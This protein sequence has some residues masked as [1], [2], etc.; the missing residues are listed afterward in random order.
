MKE[1][2]KKK[3]EKK[4]EQ[5]KDYF[6]EDEEAKEK[7]KEIEEN[8]S[9]KENESSNKEQIKDQERGNE[10]NG[11]QEEEKG[12]D[13]DK[14]KFGKEE[15]KK[16]EIE[17]DEEIYDKTIKNI[18]LIND[19]V[20]CYI[21]NENNKKQSVEIYDVIPKNPNNDCM[22]D[23]AVVSKYY[24]GEN[25]YIPYYIP[26]FKKRIKIY[27]S[28]GKQFKS[29]ICFTEDIKNIIKYFKMKNPHYLDKSSNKYKAFSSENDYKVFLFDK[30][31]II[32]DISYTH[33]DYEQLKDLYQKKENIYKKKDSKIATYLKEVNDNIYNYSQNNNLKEE[34]I[35][36][37]IGRNLFFSK[38]QNI[39]YEGKK[40]TGIYGN[41]SSGKSISLIIFNKYAEF[42][43]LYLNLKALKYSFQ[44]E[45]YAGILPNEV[46]NI[47]IK[48][49]KSYKDYE[50]FIKKIYESTFNTFDEFIDSI[51]NNFIE[52]KA[53]IFLDQYSHDLF[54]NEFIEK[55]KQLVNKKNANIKLLLINSMNDKWSRKIFIDSIL[56]FFR[57]DETKDD[58]EFIFISKL[59]TE[60][61]KPFEKIDENLI[62]YLEPF[63]YLPKYYSLIMLKKNNIDDFVSKTKEKIKNKIN[64]FLEENN[65]EDYLIQMNDVRLKIDEEID[66]KFFED[67]NEIIPFKYFYIE[68]EYVNDMPKAYLKCHF[69][70]IKEIW[71]EIIYSKTLSLFDGEIKY[72][73]SIIGSLLELNFI[74]QCQD[75]KDKFSLGIDCIVE[76]DS[77]YKMGNIT[78]RSTNNYQNKNILLIQKNENAPCFDVGFLNSKDTFEPSMTY[79]QIKKTSTDNK[80]NKSTTLEIFNK[81][82]I[83]FEKLF[84][85]KPK[86]C[87]LIYI[88]LINTNIKNNIQSFEKI[89]NKEQKN[90]LDK[91]VFDYIKKINDLDYFCT[92]DNILLYYFYPNKG[93]FYIRKG[94]CFYESKLDLCDNNSKITK[95]FPLKITLLC[96]KKE[97][98]FSENEKH[99]QEINEKYKNKNIKDKFIYPNCCKEYQALVYHFINNYCENAVIKTY[100]ELEKKLENYMIYNSQEDIILLGIIK[101]F[102]NNTNDTYSIKSVIYENYI[103]DFNNLPNKKLIDTSELD[104]KEYDLLVWIQFQ[105]FKLNGNKIFKNE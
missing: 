75:K 28:K 37:T 24:Y 19:D 44:T 36:Y 52:W 61:D 63:G 76:L 51:I 9:Q 100:L 3:N 20:I 48:N 56:K 98:E 66:L 73:G 105:K 57:K 23:G 1:E 10:V 83:T 79:I 90:N 8:N 82:K 85:I 47:Y 67:H 92:Q 33:I 94:S 15:E 64:K 46:M 81:N 88:T 29:I 21:G 30:S 45:G 42:P 97:R 12:K 31:E 99:A 17:R 32:K 86:S 59:L 104:V 89:R 16:K 55:L 50:G 35:F 5:E 54:N 102:G 40:I 22:F 11:E 43:T 65:K 58:I 6:I 80:V 77:L 38:L 70:L 49:N 27:N 71:N 74:S 18:E 87:Y 14:E 69:P 25:Q 103:F 2:K 101:N 95:E 39:F 84:G 26:L 96:K 13:K 4:R 68:T 60:E 41:Y 78:K 62:S 72:T 93:K 34:K 53:L 91:R 7:P